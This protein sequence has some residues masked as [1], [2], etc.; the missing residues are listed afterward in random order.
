MISIPAARLPR[1]SQNLEKMFQEDEEPDYH[2]WTS[3][4]LNKE[5]TNNSQLIISGVGLRSNLQ[6]A[7]GR[8]EGL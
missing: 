5:T 4:A 1:S 6:Q 8:R 2:T 7:I 3:D